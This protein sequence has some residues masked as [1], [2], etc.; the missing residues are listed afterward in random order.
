[1]FGGVAAPTF[2][3]GPTWTN[4]Q[5]GTATVTATTSSACT[6]QLDY[7]PTSSY[8]T[9]S[10]D[11]SG[12]SHS[13][14][15]TASDG[16]YHFKLTPNGGSAS[17]DALGAVTSPLLSH[18]MIYPHILT[19]STAGY[20]WLLS[21]QDQSA[22]GVAT[23]VYPVT[24]SLG[25]TLRPQYMTYEGAMYPGVVFNYTPDATSGSPTNE[26][27]G[28]FRYRNLGVSGAVLTWNV[29]SWVTSGNGMTTGKLDKLLV[30]CNS[31]ALGH[32]DVLR[33]GIAVVSNVTPAGSG[34]FGTIVD[35]TGVELTAG[36]TVGIRTNGAGV[37]GEGVRLGA[38]MGY[39]S[40][41]TFPNNVA[42][43]VMRSGAGSDNKLQV[44]MTQYSAAGTGTPD[45][46]ANG[47]NSD[48]AL[49]L[50]PTGSPVLFV[51]GA[52]HQGPAGTYGQETSITE[53][54]T[55]DGVT[56]TPAQ[57]YWRAKVSMTRS[58]TAYYNPGNPN[59]G[60][61]VT[62]YTGK[63][64]G[65]RDDWQI[66]YN[67][68]LDTGSLYVMHPVKNFGTAKNTL[69]GSSS[70]SVLLGGLPKTW[71]DSTG[72][73]WAYG[74]SVIAGI[75]QY[76]AAGAGSTLFDS[77]Y[78]ANPKNYT[79]I[80][81]STGTNVASGTVKRG[82]GVLF[83]VP[84]TGPVKPSI[85]ATSCVIGSDGVT[86][87][88]KPVTTTDAISGAAGLTFKRSGSSISGGQTVTNNNDGTITVT[89]TGAN[90][91]LSSDTITVDNDTTLA[92]AY[93]IKM[94]SASGTAVVN[95]SAQ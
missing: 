90:K 73:V 67:A 28:V 29:P 61:L 47:D 91:V 10:T 3:V 69:D 22:T 53:V 13:F 14:T 51:G 60:T 40:T 77:R 39:S 75:A 81:P 6:V 32:F 52:A 82:L 80:A 78:L 26:N 88:V 2:T 50:A 19:A 87:L 16:I 68:N 35:L 62:S 72:V 41:G 89:L 5:D 94:A 12:T 11:S 56:W 1:M 21:N 9:N 83:S 34:Y 79:R 30:F 15:V 84:T 65:L 93:G 74:G 18:F 54:W 37:G 58:S 71:T 7:G 33:N 92:D 38:I 24:T 48:V 49:E 8:G 95:H 20:W 23:G 4:N 70:E 66:T 76:H 63:S 86:I 44:Q 57:G 43:R 31:G 25:A 36:D 17:A 42:H 59:I 45:I 55:K 27:D 85:A 46:W 64:F